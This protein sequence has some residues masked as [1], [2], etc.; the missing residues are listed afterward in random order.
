MTADDSRMGQRIRT[1]SLTGTHLH[2]KETKRIDKQAKKDK[3]NKNIYIQKQTNEKRGKTTTSWQ[4]NFSTIKV[5]SGK[6]VRFRHRWSQATGCKKPPLL[7]PRAQMAK[8]TKGRTR[9]SMRKSP[10]KKS[11]LN[12]SD[13][14]GPTWVKNHPQ[15]SRA[16]MVPFA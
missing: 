12:I 2:E 8:G 1:A 4:N 6:A 5:F 9:T 11:L 16:Q 13:T 14:D 15:V 7:K 10:L 3:L